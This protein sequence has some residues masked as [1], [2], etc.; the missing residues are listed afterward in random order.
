MQY[1]PIRMR[2]V[3][4]YRMSLRLALDFLIGSE[5]KIRKQGEQRINETDSALLVLK[6]F[7]SRSYLV[8]KQNIIVLVFV[9]VIKIPLETDCG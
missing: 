3:S 7:S 1:I 5:M 4:L 2:D 8:F 9:L 6:Y